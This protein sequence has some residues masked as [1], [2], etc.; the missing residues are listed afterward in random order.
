MKSPVFNSK[1]KN[2]LNEWGTNIEPT[3]LFKCPNN[4]YNNNKFNAIK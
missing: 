4:C 1:I 2:I 3:Q